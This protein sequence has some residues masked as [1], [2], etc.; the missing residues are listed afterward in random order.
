VAGGGNGSP[1]F[2]QINPSQGETDN[3]L[4]KVNQRIAFLGLFNF[5]LV[6]NPKR[7]PGFMKLGLFWGLKQNLETRVFKLQQNGLFSVKKT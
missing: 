7:I 6:S 1:R 5:G 2:W 4:V 3:G